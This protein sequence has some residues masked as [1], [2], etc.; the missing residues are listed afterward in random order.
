[1][2]DE[3]NP[4]SSLVFRQTPP[5]QISLVEL[6]GKHTVP[7]P[8]QM[9][10]PAQANWKHLPLPL[11]GVSFGFPAQGFFFFFLFPFFLAAASVPARTCRMPLAPSV[12]R[13]QFTVRRDGDAVDVRGTVSMGWSSMVCLLASAAGEMPDHV[14]CGALFPVRH[15]QFSPFGRLAGRQRMAPGLEMT[16]PGI[17]AVCYEL[18]SAPAAALTA[19]GGWTASSLVLVGACLPTRKSSNAGGQWWFVLSLLLGPPCWRGWRWRC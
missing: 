1:V 5:Q 7:G 17:A 6:P 3:Q 11:H 10:R 19:P 12:A 14:Q 4:G 9:G 18:D 2:P 13:T 8:S 15:E 16:S